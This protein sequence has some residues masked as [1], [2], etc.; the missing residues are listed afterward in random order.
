MATRISF[1]THYPDRMKE[2]AGKPTYFVE[3]I[4]SGLKYKYHQE[5]SILYNHY[6]RECRI[7][8]GKEW[9]SEYPN[10]MWPYYP[11]TTTIRSNYEYWKS[12][13]G[14][15]IQPFFWA[16]KPYRS[17]QVVFCPEVRLKEVYRIIIHNIREIQNK[18]KHEYILDRI[19]V[20]EWWLTPRRI[21]ELIQN[22]GFDDPDHF[23]MWFDKDF[24][25]AYLE[26]ESVEI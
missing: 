12:K 11:K 16:G 9:D 6:R 2:L 18:Y 25:G 7:K 23:W 1:S 17:K 26:F 8:T 14:Q 19:R 21:E 10:I 5:K 15:L 4:W 22:E 13:E 3:K 20:D 24:D